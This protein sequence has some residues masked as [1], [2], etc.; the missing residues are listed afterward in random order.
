MKKLFLL[1][2]LLGMVAVGCSK[3]EG[4]NE[5]DIPENIFFGLDKES[6]TFSPYGGSVDVIVYSN[7]KW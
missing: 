6:V 3:D 4:G 5:K 1:L 7:Y 2:A